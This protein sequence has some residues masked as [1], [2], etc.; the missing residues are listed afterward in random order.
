M[1]SS[2]ALR[3]SPKPGALTAATWRVRSNPSAFLTVV[4]GSAQYHDRQERAVG[5]LTTRVASASPSTS[6]AMITSG[7]P[8]RATCSSHGRRSFIDESVDSAGTPLDR[9]VPMVSSLFAEIVPT[10]PIMLPLTGLD[11]FLSSP[12]MRS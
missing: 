6:S 7:R 1:S 9:I 11:I 4:V 2:I 12:T 8:P 5:L 3:R 10:W